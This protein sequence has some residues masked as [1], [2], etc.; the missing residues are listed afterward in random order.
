VISIDKG[1]MPVVNK[2][3]ELIIDTIHY[4]QDLNPYLTSL[5]LNGMLLLVWFMGGWSQY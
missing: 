2:R 5:T 3:I 4:V 1:Q